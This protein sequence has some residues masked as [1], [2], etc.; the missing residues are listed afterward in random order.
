MDWLK[1]TLVSWL[2]YSGMTQ[3]ELPSKM[4]M[5]LQSRAMICVPLMSLMS[6]FIVVGMGVKAWVESSCR[7]LVVGLKACR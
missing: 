1:S 7:F 5:R 4:A 6:V 2:T 3:D